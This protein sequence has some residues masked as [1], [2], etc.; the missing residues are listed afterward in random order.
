MKFVKLTP[1]QKKYYELGVRDAEQVQEY[2]KR[3]ASR[4]KALAESK[5]RN[6]VFNANDTHVLVVVD[7]QYD[8]VDG[9]LGTPEARAVVPNVVARIERFRKENPNGMIIATRDFHDMKHIGCLDEFAN[10]P[11]HCCSFESSQIVN[12]VLEAL[13]EDCVYCDPC[14]IGEQIDKG[15]TTIICQKNI[16]AATDII[17]NC[18]AVYASRTYKDIRTR[19]TQEDIDDFFTVEFVGVC[20]DICV[21]SSAIA[22]QIYPHNDTHIVVDASCCAGTTPEKHRA[23][24]EVMKSLCMEV[25]NE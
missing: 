22:L 20:T 2:E 11:T 6:N 24:L 7:M 19:E 16:F 10:I 15:V 13:G 12:P 9:V 25:I 3:S 21:I 8:F 23:A 5:Q 14:G 1:E 18:L 4:I 17:H